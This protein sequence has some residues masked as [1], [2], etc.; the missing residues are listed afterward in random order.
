MWVWF[1]NFN[2][3]NYNILLTETD[4]IGNVNNLKVR[5]GKH[6]S[7]ITDYTLKPLRT[8]LVLCG[9]HRFGM[10]LQDF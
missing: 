7:V 5:K 10:T 1:D 9:Y 4:I 6:K 8:F 3:Q 2:Y